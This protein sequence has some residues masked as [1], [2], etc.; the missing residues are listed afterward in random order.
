PAAKPQ[1]QQRAEPEQ[2]RHGGKERALQPRQPLVVADV[3]L[4]GLPESRYFGRLLPV[5]AHDAHA[6]QRLLHHGAHAGK[7]LL[8]LLEGLVNGR[9]KQPDG[10]RDQRQRNQR[11]QREPYVERKHQRQTDDGGDKGVGQ[12]HHGG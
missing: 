8:H 7:T 9:A 11:N 4:V 10:N 6:G 12:I 2:Q 5:G 1:R 3:V